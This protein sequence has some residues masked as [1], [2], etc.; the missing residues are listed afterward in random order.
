MAMPSLALADTMP[1]LDFKNPLLL[2]QVVWGA[3]IFAL[4]YVALSWFSLPKLAGVL[5]KRASTIAEDLETATSAKLG[6]DQALAEIAASRHATAIESQAAIARATEQAKAAAM[7]ES[8]RLTAELDAQ[9]AE[10]ETRI[11]TARA[12]AMGALAEVSVETAAALIHRLTG[13]RASPQHLA[14]AVA[15]TL[16]A[17][18][19]GA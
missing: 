13:K 5:A 6:A 18:G 7:V 12:A 17:R 8:A 14:G 3:I 1:Q 16:A 11:Q 19:I 2:S 10:S 9:L 15:T 4:F